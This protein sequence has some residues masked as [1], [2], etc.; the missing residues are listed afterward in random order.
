MYD[1]IAKTAHRLDGE[2]SRKFIKMAKDISNEE[3]EEFDASPASS[4][5]V[6]T[7]LKPE[8]S[9]HEEIEINS[10]YSNIKN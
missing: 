8:P 3:S 7:Y 2:L 10:G 6:E 1:I 4:E 5:I 9:K